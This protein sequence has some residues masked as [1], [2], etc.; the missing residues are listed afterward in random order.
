MDTLKKIHKFLDILPGY[1][2]IIFSIFTILAVLLNLSFDTQ[3]QAEMLE[4]NFW[5]VIDQFD[6]I[7]GAVGIIWGVGIKVTRP[8]IK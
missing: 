1:K 7:I 2:T 5:V 8:F 3:I 4:G 6:V